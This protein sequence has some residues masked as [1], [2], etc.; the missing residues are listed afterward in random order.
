VDIQKATWGATLPM[1]S[2]VSGNKPQLVSS[3][4]ASSSTLTGW[5]TAVAKYDV[6]RAVLNSN[7]A[8]SKMFTL[9][10]EVQ[11]Q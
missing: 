5:T 10:V 1:T 4:D 3:L 6:I 9:G 11:K 7:Y 8:T 2:I